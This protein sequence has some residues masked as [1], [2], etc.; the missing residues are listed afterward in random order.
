M[1]AIGAQSNPSCPPNNCWYA[2]GSQHA[3]DIVNFGFA[4]GSVRGIRGTI[5][6]NTLIFITGYKD[7][8]VVNFD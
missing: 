4:D 8:Q 5:D 6:F 2:F 7:N 3:G 1:C